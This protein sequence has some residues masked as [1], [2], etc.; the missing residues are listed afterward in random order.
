MRVITILKVRIH[1][2]HLRL[3]PRSLTSPGYVAFFFQVQ[4]K[5]EW[6]PQMS[7]PQM[8]ADIRVLSIILISLKLGKE[9][10]VTS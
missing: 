9:K 2:G 3:S 1:Y 6:E 10:L 8:P 5:A 7:K 4:D